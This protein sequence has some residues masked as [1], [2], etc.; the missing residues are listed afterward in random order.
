MSERST[1]NLR[2]RPHI[3]PDRGE[4]LIVEVIRGGDV[5]ATIYGSREGVHIVSERL[6]HNAAAFIMRVNDAPSIVI[7]LLAVGEP[8]PWCAQHMPIKPCPVCGGEL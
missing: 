8:C 6:E 4:D 7:P 5:V 2:V 1:L 3:H